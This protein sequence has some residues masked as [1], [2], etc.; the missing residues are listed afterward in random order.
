MNRLSLLFLLISCLASVT[1]ADVRS[2]QLSI[3]GMNCGFC[4]VTIRKALEKVD[5]VTQAHVDYETKSAVVEFDDQKTNVGQLTEATKN[6]G[7]PSSEF[8]QQ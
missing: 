1:W 2:V 4:P 8:Q 6:A 5:G 7:Y 3:P